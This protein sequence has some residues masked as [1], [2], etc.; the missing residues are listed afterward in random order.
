[1]ESNLFLKGVSIGLRRLNNSDIDGNYDNWLNNQEITKFNSHG[2]FPISKENLFE[3]VKNAYNNK[4]A[5]IL[6]VVHIESNLH[7]GNISLQNINWV[8]R[9]AEIAFLLGEKKFWGKGIMLEAGTLLINHGFKSLNLH[10]LYCG[11]SSENIGM[12]K[13]AIKLGMQQEGMRIDAIF[14]D[15]KYFD[16]IEFGL[17]KTYEVL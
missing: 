7:I 2:R 4:N 17:I 3:Y 14:K 15:G 6:A 11:T 5:L 12:Q 16:I 9:N 8:D 13:L 1:M 10:R